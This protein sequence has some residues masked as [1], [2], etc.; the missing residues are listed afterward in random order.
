MGGERGWVGAERELALEESADFDVRWLSSP[1]FVRGDG[2][3]G[4]WTSRVS[5]LW[6]TTRN[7]SCLAPKE[8]FASPLLSGATFSRLRRGAVAS[9]GSSWLRFRTSRVPFSPRA[10]AGTVLAG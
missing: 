5:G 9:W 6:G 1:S 7:E 2:A 8:G 4:T 3:G 10:G